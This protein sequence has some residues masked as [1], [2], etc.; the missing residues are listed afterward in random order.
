MAHTQIVRAHIEGKNFTLYYD[1]DQLRDGNLTHLS[2]DG[3]IDW[4]RLRMQFVFLEPIERLFTAKSPAYRELN[5]TKP[6]DLPARSFVI[7]S[8]SLLLNGIEALGSFLTPKGA[9]NK[10]RFYAFIDK[11]MKPWGAATPMGTLKAILWDHFRNGI[12]HGFCIEHGGIDNE[13]DIPP[14]W[15]VVRDGS[16]MKTYLEIGPNAFFRDFRMGVD[17]FFEEVKTDPIHRTAFLSRL[18]EVYPA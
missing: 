3:K 9:G 16:G 4:L 11:Y 6:D 2:E 10:Q 13:A 8:F 1:Y 7:A 12:A 14:G 15:R 5:S 18:Q 17:L